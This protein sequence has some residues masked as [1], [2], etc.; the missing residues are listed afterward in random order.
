MNHYN[1]LVLKD[2]VYFM[3]LYVS[4]ISYDSYVYLCLLQRGTQHPERFNAAPA[5]GQKTLLSEP[6]PPPCRDLD[7]C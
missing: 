6:K 5:G 1:L 7:A 2:D 3:Y 4:I